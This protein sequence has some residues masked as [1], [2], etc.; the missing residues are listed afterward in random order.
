[1]LDHLPSR[2]GSCCAARL[3]FHNRCFRVFFIPLKPSARH[4]AAGL[5]GLG[6]GRAV[7][8]FNGNVSW[9]G[10]YRMNSIREAVLSKVP[11]VTLGFWIIKIAATT[12]GETGGDTLSMTMNLGYIV[13]SAIFFAFF[14]VT[15]AS[16]V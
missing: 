2:T 9:T 8:S 7:V 6:T 10:D 16:Q 12:L 13:S 5:D 4:L 1:M 11:Q 3:I 14:I 15:V